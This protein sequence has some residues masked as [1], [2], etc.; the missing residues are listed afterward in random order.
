MRK[1]YFKAEQV[2]IE[3]RELLALLPVAPWIAAI[4][5]RAAQAQRAALH[6][7]SGDDLERLR[8]DFNASRSKVRFLYLLSPT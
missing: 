3:R 6:L 4:P 5:S 1:Y 2:K 8:Q 7:L